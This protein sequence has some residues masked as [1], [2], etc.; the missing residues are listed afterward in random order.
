MGVAQQR[1]SAW[2]TVQAAAVEFTHQ[3]VIVLI[4]AFIY[5]RVRGLT[6]GKFATASEHGLQVAAFEHRLGLE[7]ETRMQSVILGHGWLITLVNWM[8][9]FGHWP[10]II[11]TLVWLYAARRPRFLL[12]RNA[13]FISGA[14]GLV[15]FAT[16]AVAPPRLL[17]LGI[18]DTVT[19]RSVSYRVL[20][21]PALVNQY[22]ALPSLHL[23]WNLL[24]GIVLFGATR[25][26]VV[27]VFAVLSPIAMALAVVMTG[28]HYLVDGILG[29]LI[30]LFGPAASTVVTPRLVA[31]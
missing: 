13:M 16:Y 6:E 26:V 5:F 31:F 23:G 28:N 15:I 21:P 3:L 29:C 22:A 18:V 30:A 2:R 7:L 17:D 14:I 1:S 10:V 25:N 19:Q 20:Q 9:M 8:Y 24:V 4:G 11:V 27:R 12:L